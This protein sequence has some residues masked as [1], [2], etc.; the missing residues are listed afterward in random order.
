[1]LTL[2]ASTKALAEV[3]GK[4]VQYGTQVIKINK[5]IATIYSKEFHENL[6]TDGFYFFSIFMFF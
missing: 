6:S 3:V 5:T 4:P 2:I 1:M